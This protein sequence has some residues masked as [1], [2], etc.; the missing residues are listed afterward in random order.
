MQGLTAAVSTPSA[1]DVPDL[2]SP[3]TGRPVRRIAPDRRVLGRAL[4]VVALAAV[5]FGVHLAIAWQQYRR[6][7]VGSYDLVIFDQAVRGYAGLSAPIS[8]VKGVH[9][10]FGRDF[11]VLGD[12]FS[13]ALALLA[14][15]YWIWADPRMLLVAQAALFSL[16]V[17]VVWVFARRVLGVPAAYLVAAAFGLG[18]PLLTASAVG[19]HEVAFAVPLIAVMLERAQAGRYRQ[20]AMAAVALLFVKEDLGLV[21]AAFGVLLLV[22]AARSPA[23]RGGRRPGRA[24]GAVLAA[25]GLAASALAVG[26]VIPHFGGRS[27]YYW[28]YDALGPDAPSA[29]WF[30]LQNPLET[31]QLAF[32]PEAKLETVL[33]LVLSAGLL[34]LLSPV[35]L[36]ALPLLAERLLSS[37]PNV[38]TAGHHYDAFLAPILICAAVEVAGRLPARI[39]RR[40]HPGLRSGGGMAWAALLAVAAAVVSLGPLLHVGDAGAWRLTARDRAAAA[41]AGAVPDRALVE[42]DNEVGPHLT[43]RTRVLLLDRTPREAEWVLA[44]T[45]EHSFPFR[46]VAEQRERVRFLRFQGYRVVF[47]REGYVVLHRDRR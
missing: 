1:T 33:R 5:A 41:A 24:L 7:Q 15:L 36:L 37:N 13:P 23:G 34:C 16:A 25:G 14:P 45:A 47:E 32:T 29:L 8:L 44:D 40:P 26:V 42:A 10:D 39:G 2:A 38:W 9:N 22:R 12:H 21:V 30:V 3:A 20:A 35:M 4:G 11:S 27:G 18:W 28:N 6:F 43:G 19:F 31:V 17:P 46:S